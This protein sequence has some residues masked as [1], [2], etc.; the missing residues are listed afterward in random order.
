LQWGDVEGNGR[1][2]ASD[3][4]ILTAGWRQTE[5][6]PSWDPRF[7]LLGTGMLDIRAMQ[8]VTSRWGQICQGG[9]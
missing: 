6:D 1:V 7:D 8:R 9:W 4:Q 3:F 2:E 5:D